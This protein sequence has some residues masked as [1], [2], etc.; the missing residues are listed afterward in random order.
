MRLVRSSHGNVGGETT[1]RID[2]RS[3]DDDSSGVRDRVAGLIPQDV[4]EEIEDVRVT[5]EPVAT[6]LRG[7][8]VDQAALHG[9][10]NR[11]QNLGLELVEVRRTCRHRDRPSSTTS[12]EVRAVPELFDF[13]ITGTIGRSSPPAYRVS[14][15]SP[16]P[17][18]PW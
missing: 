11:L 17:S 8:V 1:S 4:L 12:L 5:I 3:F 16:N 6:T 14:A 18:G 2:D 15:P 9:V 13:V 7:P 10:I